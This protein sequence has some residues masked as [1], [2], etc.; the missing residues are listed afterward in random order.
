MPIQSV[1][2]AVNHSAARMFDLVS[3]ISE[4]PKFVPACKEII[5]TKTSIENKKNVIIAKMTVG[6]GLIKEDFISKV[7]LDRK[8]KIILVNNYDGLFK[9]L[10]NAWSFKDKDDGCIVNFTIDFEL[11]NTPIS[12]MIT[13]MFSK[14]FNKYVSAF[15]KRANEL[16]F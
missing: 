5:V 15:E 10:N 8:N 16:Y 4:Y 13:L 2:K 6:I 1:T 11:M 9:N 7:I 3:D 12:P 14:V